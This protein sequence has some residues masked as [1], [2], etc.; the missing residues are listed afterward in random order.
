MI[1]CA[2]PRTDTDLLAARLTNS[3]AVYADAFEG[4]K[5]SVNALLDTAHT[6]QPYFNTPAFLALV[7]DKNRFLVPKS[8]RRI[9]II[10]RV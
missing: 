4:G 5:L 1:C 6:L 7:D 8:L 9:L 2:G 3:K 10:N